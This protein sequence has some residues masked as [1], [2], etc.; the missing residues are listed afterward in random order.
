MNNNIR[1]DLRH[2]RAFIAVTE[3]LHFKKAADALC[4]TQP[5]L[6]RLIKG[7]ED[8][9]GTALFERTTRQVALSHS[10]KLFLQECQEALRHLERGVQLA[11]RASNGDIG[12]I[13]IAYND[14][15]INGVLPEILESFKE[16]YPDI[17]V[18]LIYM[19]SHKQH[20][21]V[22]DH[23]ID[24]G[25]MIGPVSIKG[26]ETHRAAVENIVVILPKRHRLAH[27][28]FVTI[29]DLR[30]EKFILGTEEGWSEFRS[31]V[32]RLCMKSGFTPNIIQEASTSSGI[33]GLVAANMGISFYSDC[34]NKFKRDDLVSV[35]LKHPDN[36]IETIAAWNS[37]FITPSFQLFRDMLY[38]QLDA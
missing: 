3:T 1:F 35:P 37:A 27:S 4:I 28:S 22:L 33:F 17:I 36:H 2:L 38:Q 12:R 8:C 19:P 16:A 13:T 11:Q 6:S 32:F 26:V 14:F 9:V 5:A 20:N 29:D 18:N 24:A 7:L 34:V 21:A 31:H 25:F 23:D 30:H 10:G 15:S